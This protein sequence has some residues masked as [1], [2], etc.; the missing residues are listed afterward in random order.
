MDQGRQILRWKKLDRSASTSNKT[1]PILELQC[2]ILIL[3]IFL[4][5]VCYTNSTP[6]EVT[7][8]FLRESED[9][10]HRSFSKF[11]H[12]RLNVITNLVAL[13]TDG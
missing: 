8:Q 4:S 6:N 12:I 3:E 7:L 2:R 9:G 11:K 10:K 13:E 5:R 1:H